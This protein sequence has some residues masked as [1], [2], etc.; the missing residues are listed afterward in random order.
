MLVVGGRCT[1]LR[2]GEEGTQTERRG[3]SGVASTLAL[4]GRDRWS[5]EWVL[6]SLL[7]YGA[8]G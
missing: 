6:R 4:D 3:L 5:L 7:S 2:S 1:R 8:E